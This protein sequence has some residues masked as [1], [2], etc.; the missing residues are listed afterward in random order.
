VRSFTYESGFPLRTTNPDAGA[1]FY[2]HHGGYVP[3][4]WSAAPL[5]TIGLGQIVAGPADRG[6]SAP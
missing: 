5:D 4:A 1:G 2:S 6:R 3:Y